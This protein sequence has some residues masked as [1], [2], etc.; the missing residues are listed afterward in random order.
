M[1][2]E[3]PNVIVSFK[4]LGITSIQ[5]AKHGDIAIVLP[6]DPAI[7][8][9][10]M[11]T[12]DDIPEAAK[13]YSKEQIK[14]A[15]K[16]YQLAPRK[17]LAF[18]VTTPTASG[19]PTTTEIDYTDILKKLTRQKFDWLVV[20]GISAKGA[21]D[22]ADWI[23]SQRTQKDR[24]FKAV[25][26]N[27]KADNEGVVNFTNTTIKTADKT[28]STADY[29][30]RIAGIIA[31]TPDTIS[32]TYAPLPELVEVETY[33]D[34]EMDQKIANG[35]FFLFSDGEQ[36]K[37]ARGINSYV[38]TVQG[39]GED[40]Q[41]IKL[42][43]LMD[44]I[45]QDIKDTAHKSYIGK[46]ANSYDNRCLLITAI[47]GYFDTLETEGLLE[48]N[49]NTVEV[50]IQAVKNWRESNGLNTKA[51]LAT[52]KDQDIKEL[53]IHD[54]VFL[55]AHISMLDAIESIKLDISIE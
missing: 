7:D 33:T 43:S 34:E 15:M 41:K 38:T 31:G 28:Y 27:V 55:A 17:I 46:Y 35:E 22:I 36:I 26:P 23:K 4:E 25:L 42:V 49:Q 39:K 16:G 54:N 11:Y 14:L 10:V 8:N 13:D 37:V 50:D 2:K 24:G 30:S 19:T 51:E 20:P 53:N 44:V 52:M 3:M 6:D 48:R 40:F 47:Q 5:R 18:S 12:Q 45:K 9:V 29:C 21:A 1:A 32:C